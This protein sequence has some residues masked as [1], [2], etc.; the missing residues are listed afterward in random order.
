MGIG[1]NKRVYMV[2]GKIQ[3]KVGVFIGEYIFYNDSME[4]LKDLYNHKYIKDRCLLDGIYL[5][6]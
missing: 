3:G 5:F 1:R 4:I 6:A 2:K